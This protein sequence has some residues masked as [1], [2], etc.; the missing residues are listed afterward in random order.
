MRN[1]E[2]LIV[3]HEK[4]ERAHNYL[5]ILE[6]TKKQYQQYLEVNDLYKLLEKPP[7]VQNH[8]PSIKN[9]L[10]ANATGSIRK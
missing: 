4:N 3:D 2:D 8:T 9:P 6:Q 5:E 1:K 7:A 10:T